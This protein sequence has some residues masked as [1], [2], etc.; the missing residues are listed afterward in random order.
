MEWEGDFGI[1]EEFGKDYIL[2]VRPSIERRYGNSETM[3][4]KNGN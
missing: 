4:R 1:K 3:E 2:K